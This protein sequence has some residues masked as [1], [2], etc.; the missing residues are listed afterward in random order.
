MPALLEKVHEKI[1]EK[2]LGGALAATDYSQ[3]EGLIKMVT[4]MAL[5]TVGLAISGQGEIYDPAPAPRRDTPA[6]M[7]Q[8]G[9]RWSGSTGR[10]SRRGMRG[11]R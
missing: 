2:L 5:E 9:A 3:H 11:K 6:T 8:T 7:R 4:K 1:R 10:S